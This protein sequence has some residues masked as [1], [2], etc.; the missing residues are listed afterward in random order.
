MTEKTPKIVGTLFAI[1]LLENDRIRFRLNPSFVAQNRAYAADVAILI[2][3]LVDELASVCEADDPDGTTA[4]IPFDVRPWL[5]EEI[6]REQAA[7]EMP[8]RQ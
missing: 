6:N 8:K 4:T 2:A 5:V 7:G 1:E 3:R